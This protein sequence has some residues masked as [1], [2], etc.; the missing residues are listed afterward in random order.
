MDV[1]GG[2]QMRRHY[3]FKS[4]TSGT[5]SALAILTIAKR[6]GLRRP[7]SIPPMYVKSNSASNANFS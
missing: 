1:C 7:R 3:S 6:L 2:S 4:L 5:E